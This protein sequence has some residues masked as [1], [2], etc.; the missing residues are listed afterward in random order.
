[1]PEPN[2]SP[3][4]NVSMVVSIT[5]L[6]LKRP[7]HVF[8]FFRHAVR[9]RLQAEQ[10]QGNLTA[11][12]RKVD[13]VYHTVTAWQSKKDMQRFARSGAHAKAIA[14]FPKIATGGTYIYETD[15][16]PD[17]DEAAALWR[18]HGVEYTARR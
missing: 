4:R 15:R 5:G 1:M 13:G 16:V 12:V 3:D 18:E 10:A 11:R 17:W 9:S 14:V 7:W 6:R 8:R 2:P